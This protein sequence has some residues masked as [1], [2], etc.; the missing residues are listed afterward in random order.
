MPGGEGGSV[1]DFHE[2]VVGDLTATLR[3]RRVVH[4]VAFG[5]TGFGDVS[6]LPADQV[7]R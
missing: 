3:T 5:M 4:A 6:H 2:R 1:R 7:T